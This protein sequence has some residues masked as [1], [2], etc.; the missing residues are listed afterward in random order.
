MAPSPIRVVALLAAAASAWGQA[1]L[2]GQVVDDHDAPIAGAHVTVRSATGPPLETYSG[3][4][5][6]FRLT[7][8]GPGDYLA[9]AAHAGYF[10]LH[11]QPVHVEAGGTEV[12]LV[13]NPQREVF[14]S[15]QVG[16]LPNAVDPA[17]TQSEQRLSGT[18]V[19]D[20]PYAASNSLRNAMQ[21]I[22]GV[23]QDPTGSLHFHGGGEYQTQ[24]TLDGFDITNPIDGRYD[25]R[26]AVEGVRSLDLET[27]RETA[28]YGR[29]SAGT[30]EIQ[31]DTGTDQLHYTATNF[32]PGLETRDGFTIG[33]WTPRAGISGPIVKGHAWFSD[34]LD[35]EYN[36]GFI[37]GL[38]A[39]Q[40]TN[41]SW[42]IGNLLH[43][44]VNTTRANIL[45]ADFLSDFD[46]QA[47]LG[48]G[49]LDPTSTTS[50]LTDRQWLAAVKDSQSWGQGNLVEVGAAWQTIFR[51]QVPLGDEPYVLAPTGRS[52]NYFLNSR[53]DGR[54]DQLFVNFFPRARHAAGR[55]QLEIGADGQWLNY[56]AH[57]QRTGLTVIG[58]SGLPVYSTTFVG[59]GVF[60]QTNSNAAWYV[61]DHWQPSGTLAIDAGLR[62][63]WDRLVGRT[64]LSPR[65][66]LSWAP[67]HNARTKIT[68]G[69]AVLRDATN[70]SLFSRPLDQQAET[71]AYTAAGVPEAPV[72][73]SFVIGGNLRLPLYNQYSGGVEQGFS[74]GLS[75][76]LELMRK[77]GRDGFVYAPQG[78]AALYPISVQ[79]QL[80]GYGFGGQYALSNLRRDQYDEA[81]VTVRQNL[82]GQYGWL[83]SYTRSRADSNTVL[84][85]AN[86]Q[87]F[88]VLNNFVPMPWDAP[89]RL[90]G[91]AYLP[92]PRLGKNWAL[93]TLV[94][95][96]NGFPFSVTNEAGIVAGAVDGSRYPSNFDL[97]LHVER[98]F[99]FRGYR[100]AL[101]VGFNNLTD[102]PNPTAVNNIVDSPQFL[103]FYGDEGRHLVVRIRMFGHA[104]R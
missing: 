95:W 25:T 87:P 61:N 97:N 98:R 1:E 74:H 102:H 8:P 38:P 7:L 29:G 76:K 71:V 63:D 41:A 84:D 104:T 68:A 100:F 9:G 35:A 93:A 4:T 33:D 3:P 26:L 6:A 5:G 51:S 52:G 32:I 59:S 13:L 21:L 10:E 12:N 62:L 77:R 36:S 88:Q 20:V 40:N 37:S 28:N 69:Y 50:A 103:Q 22:P 42:A 43:A 24:Y 66:G 11:A 18:E 57:N 73:N 99:V 34:S 31:T 19:N 60:D 58:A 85:I 27:A 44:Q 65:T 16:E 79:P 48:L 54:R 45:Y 47:H 30:L 46:S 56:N 70:L 15:V 82:G 72:L 53:E 78:S 17:Q 14:Q 2:S 101:R 83:A 81:A 75:A 55:H 67:F 96:R 94:D 89:N 91:W 92:I 80:L 86:D 49:P 90:L 23:V 39:G 64:G